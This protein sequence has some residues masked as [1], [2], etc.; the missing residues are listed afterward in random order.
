MARARLLG[1]AHGRSCAVVDLRSWRALLRLALEGSSGW[2]EAWA[3]GEWA[4]PDPVQLFALF[5]RNRAGLAQPARATGPW[6]LAKRVWHWLRRNHR[7]GSRRNIQFHYD[8]GNDFYQPWL[9]AGHDL[10]ERIVRRCRQ[11]LEAAQQAKL[12]A[13]LDRTATAPGDAI[14]EIGCG[15]GSFA[16]LALRQGRKVHGI[17]LSTEQK[18]WAEARTA[19][20]DGASFALTDYRDVTGIM[21]R[22]SASRWPRRWAANIGR[23]ISR[24]S[25]AR[26]SPAAARRCRSSPSTTHCSKAMRTMSISSSATSSPADC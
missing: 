5:S 16:E 18:A 19:G 2:Y 14:L 7:G 11:S 10:F 4:S 26:S 17:T 8:L 1:G 6:R 15:W 21:T 22:W 23:P 12:Q 24:R 3:A 13:M 9:D 25:R 20:L